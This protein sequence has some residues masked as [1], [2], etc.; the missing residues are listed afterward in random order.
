MAATCGRWPSAV[1][2]WKIKLLWCCCMDL[3][4][5]WAFGSRTWKLFLSIALCLLWTC[6]ASGRA[7]DLCFPQ[8]LRRQR[9]CLWSPLNSGGP[10]WAYSPWSCWATTWAA[11]WLRPILLNIQEGECWECSSTKWVK[12]FVRLCVNIFYCLLELRLCWWTNKV[13]EW[14]GC[15]TLYRSD[16]WMMFQLKPLTLCFHEMDAKMKHS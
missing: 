1:T 5:A 14:I 12:A 9:V 4:V 15:I 16:C 3:G 2:V 8:T 7:P 6:W 13:S 10:K 11:S